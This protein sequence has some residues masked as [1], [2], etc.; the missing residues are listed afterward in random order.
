MISLPGSAWSFG[1]S[2]TDEMGLGARDTAMGMAYTAEADDFTASYYN[3]AG[4]AAQLRPVFPLRYRVETVTGKATCLS[5]SYGCIEFTTGD[6][7]VL[8]FFHGPG[9]RQENRQNVLLT[10]VVFR[11]GYESRGPKIPWLKPQFLP[12]LGIGTMLFEPDIRRPGTDT[13]P[14]SIR[15][16][17]FGSIPTYLTLAFRIS[18]YF[19]LGGGASLYTFAPENTSSVS[20]TGTSQAPSEATLRAKGPLKIAWA[21]SLGF[22]FEP[23]PNAELNTLKIGFSYRGSATSRS[24]IKT[25]LVPVLG[26]TLPG[27]SALPNRFP[28]V[29]SYVPEQFA[30][31]FGW[32]DDTWTHLLFT[33]DLV[34]KRWGNFV[35]ATGQR[36][37]HLHQTLSPHFGFE[38]R[39]V[40]GIQ[41]CFNGNCLENP[42]I[43]ALQWGYYFEPRALAHQADNTN[44]FD[45]DQHVFS[46]GLELFAPIGGFPSRFGAFV[47]GHWM[48][49]ERYHHPLQPSGLLPLPGEINESVSGGQLVAGASMT[50]YVRP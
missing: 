43:S 47:Q 24:V 40:D 22:L 34:L 14:V 3:P 28:L 11:P 30:G 48:P 5:S 13:Q 35:S 32:K 12:A 44:F 50:L 8:K 16:N 25:E 19:S 39:P 45:N 10:G 21:P 37:G 33:G 27:I 6:K 17:S 2:I 1:T 49:S 15:S 38:L 23:R 9:E 20:L 36:N 42:R 31:G 18:P 7:A 46:L 26:L 4:L 29:V 41:L